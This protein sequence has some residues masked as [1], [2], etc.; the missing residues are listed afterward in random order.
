LS[1]QKEA[2]LLL[3]EVVMATVSALEILGHGREATNFG[4]RLL[5]ALLVVEGWLDRHHQRQSLLELDD[6]MLR[7]IGISRNDAEAEAKKPFWQ[8]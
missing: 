8:L 3:L 7:D 2:D 4:P 6:H 5:R 1:L